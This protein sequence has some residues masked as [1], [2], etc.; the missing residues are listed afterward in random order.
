MTK[1][2]IARDNVKNIRDYKQFIKYFIW[3]LS[4]MSA[5]SHDHSVNGLVKVQ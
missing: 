1:V 3:L 5:L 4:E 2:Q